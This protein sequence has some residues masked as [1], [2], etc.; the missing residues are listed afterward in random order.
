MEK[1]TLSPANKP[2]IF[3]ARLPAHIT[4]DEYAAT[5]TDGWPVKVVE[6]LTEH[7]TFVDYLIEQGLDAWTRSK[8]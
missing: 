5:V 1:P 3:Y 6:H 8:G 2:G 4:A 7:E